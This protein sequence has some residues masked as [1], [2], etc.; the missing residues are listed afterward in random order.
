MSE[1][2]LSGGCAC[3]AVRYECDGE[4]AMV[5]H[6]HCRDC[7]RASGA[8]YS[9]VFAVPRAAFRQTAGKT[10]TYQYTGDS[11]QPVV[12][13]FCP[14]CGNPLF[15][16]VTVLPDLMFV[17]AA[18][19]DAPEAVTPTMHIYCDSAQ[20]WDSARDD[21]PRFGKLPG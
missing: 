17:R 19:L 4:P 21:L 2:K 12:R 13:A 11:G 16:D 8:G 7:Q 14:T 1:S 18:S 5:A 15:T 6:C 20:P 10:A 9:T 3:G